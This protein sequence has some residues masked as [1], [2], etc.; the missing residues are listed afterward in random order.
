M[1]DPRFLLFI[2][3]KEHASEQPIIDELTMKM[4]ASLRKGILG[5]E[6]PVDQIQWYDKKHERFTI[7]PI[8]GI[9]DYKFVANNGWM[10]FFTCICDVHSGAQ[11]FLLT[12][13]D[14]TNS[15]CV[16]YLA[17]HRDEVS[18]EQLDRVAQLEDGMEMPTTQEL[19][20]PQIN[21]PRMAMTREEYLR[22]IAND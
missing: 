4:T 21:R 11:N 10:G 15:L 6:V 19:H 13:G 18:Q 9:D 22:S 5:A 1:D 8:K 16:H 12:N 20:P 17:Y 3:A 2:H 14:V 7:H